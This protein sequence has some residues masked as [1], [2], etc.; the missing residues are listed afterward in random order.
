MKNTKK[1]IQNEM[2]N[3]RTKKYLITC[4]IALF[5]LLVVAVISVCSTEMVA[6]ASQTSEMNITSVL[7]GV[8]SSSYF[9]I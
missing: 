4:I 2:I 5:V 8:N 7:T 6:Y 9:K 1:K 3:V